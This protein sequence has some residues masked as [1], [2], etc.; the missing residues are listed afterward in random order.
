MEIERKFLISGWPEHLPMIRE[1]VLMQGY[2]S[3]KPVVRIRS[4]KGANGT[5]YI[6]CFKG[7]GTL[8]REEIEL[9]IEQDIFR[10]L[11]QLLP[12]PLLCKEQRVYRLPTGEELECNLVEP[13]SKTAFF[14][15]EVEFDSVAE[16]EMFTP[17]AFLGQEKTEAEDFSMGAYWRS[18]VEKKKKK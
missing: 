15:A 9:E 3:T 16:A 18:Y 7:K 17:P 4:H 6:L 1:E 14:Y 8:A 2:L 12:A 5:R 10:K 11:A 13:G